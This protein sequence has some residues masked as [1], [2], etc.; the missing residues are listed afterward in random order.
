M[1]NNDIVEAETICKVCKQHFTIKYSKD[2]ITIKCKCGVLIMY[3]NR[4][5]RFVSCEEY[6]K[7]K[8]DTN[9]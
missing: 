1:V 7:F 3:H 8:G 4:N 9:G 5:V 2:F 6:R